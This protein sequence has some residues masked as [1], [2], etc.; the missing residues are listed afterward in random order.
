M[1]NINKNTLAILILLSFNQTAN[2]TEAIEIDLKDESYSIGYE[3]TRSLALLIEKTEK[4]H[5]NLT[6]DKQRV[7]SGITDSLMGNKPDLDKYKRTAA[8]TN[9]DS[10]TDKQGDNLIAEENYQNG[11]LAQEQAK[12]VPGA[13]A[14]PSGLLYHMITVVKDGKKPTEESVVTLNYVGLLVN[15][16]IFDSSKWR[17]NSSR[18]VV[19]DLHK[20]LQEGV[21][22]MK[23]GEEFELIIKPSLAYGDKAQAGIPPNSTLYYK[24]TLE[25][26][27]DRK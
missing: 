3:F 20:G 15:G 27:S 18:F 8:L 2:A 7:I 5:K 9:L 26:V 1:F 13:M 25:K 22:L 11:M 16:E 21:L 17:K 24:V 10:L 4:E 14:T 6:F 19:K 12:Q 23:E